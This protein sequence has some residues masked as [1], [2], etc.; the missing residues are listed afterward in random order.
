MSESESPFQ[1]NQ[2]Y[3]VQINYHALLLDGSIATQS[4]GAE[5]RVFNAPTALMEALPIFH[6]KM[7]EQGL[8]IWGLK[9][10]V[11]LAN[12]ETRRPLEGRLTPIPVER[13][14]LWNLFRRR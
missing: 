14:R 8:K 10:Q 5:Y 3:R 12:D 2:I 7:G 11:D 1:G 4:W 13:R 9:V 6:S